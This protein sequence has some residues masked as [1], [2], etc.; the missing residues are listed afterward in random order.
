MKPVP[1]LIKV[2]DWLYACEITP[3]QK[4]QLKDHIKTAVFNLMLENL[5][6]WSRPK[7]P[8]ACGGI[9]TS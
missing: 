1:V 9:T 5:H 8:M 6:D 7:S 4:E 3:E 2:D